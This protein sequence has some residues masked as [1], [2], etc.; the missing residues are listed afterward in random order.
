[1]NTEEMIARYIKLRDKVDML[2]KAFDES[3]APYKAGMQAIEGQVTIEMD[4]LGVDSIKCNGVG[5]AFRKTTLSVKVED[6]E[7]FMDFVFD[8]RREGFLTSHV[9]KEAVEEYIESHK[10]SPPGI[11]VVPILKTQ[12]RRA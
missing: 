7:A 5:T 12:F 3:L 1:M 9:A 6:R 11:A 8:G 10:S 4:N 2:N